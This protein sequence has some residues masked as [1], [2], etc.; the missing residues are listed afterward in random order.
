MPPKAVPRIQ[1]P[2][3]ATLVESLDLAE[4]PLIFEGGVQSW[5]AVS[6]TSPTRNWTRS[7]L[8]HLIGETS[9]DF[10]HSACHQHPDF[11][12]AELAKMFARQRATFNQFFEQVL[13]GPAAERSRHLFTGDEQFLMRRRDGITQVD[14]ALKP[15][16]ADVD[17]YALVPEARIYSVWA[18]FSGQG[19]RTWLHYDNN[20][21]HNFNAQ[22]QGRKHCMLFDPDELGQMA[23][24]SLGGGNPAHNCSGLDVERPAEAGGIDLARVTTWEATL[25]QGDLLF[26]PAWWW[27]SFE[28]VGQLNANVNVWWKPSVQRVNATLLRQAWLDA[29]S[30]AAIKVAPQSPEAALLRRIDAEMIK[31]RPG[32]YR[33]RTPES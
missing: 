2:Q 28:H 18:W 27:H 15:L 11:H 32:E 1:T 19:V 31:T 22:L 17:L 3:L 4:T 20:G 6:H 29:V 5:P 12:Q 30:R 9:V 25:E 10:K 24:F 7:R 14:E 33:A 21:C 23:P 26:I 16:L 13:E 8:S